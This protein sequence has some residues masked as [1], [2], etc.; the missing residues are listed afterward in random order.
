M[1]QNKVRSGVS[2]FFFLF[3]TVRLVVCVC[4]PLCLRFISPP[5]SLLH[6]CLVFLQYRCSFKGIQRFSSQYGPVSSLITL[7]KEGELSA[8]HST[9]A[10]GPFSAAQRHN[11][12]SSF[13]VFVHLVQ[14]PTAVWD[15]LDQ[16]K[17]PYTML[18]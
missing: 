1:R 9:L 18:D 6:N 15:E 14:F 16:S 13:L 4:T 2:F 17:G 8:L 11:K 5:P 3:F 12:N 7:H 10:S